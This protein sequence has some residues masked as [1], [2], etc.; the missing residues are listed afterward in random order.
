MNI[1]ISNLM[2]F[3]TYILA[4]IGVLAFVVS[5]IVQAVKEMPGLSKIP[6]AAVALVVSM[7]ICPVAMLAAMQYYKQPVTW[8][9]VFACIIAAFVVYLVS[10]GGWS[11]LKEI[12]DRTKYDKNDK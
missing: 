11:K 3:M 1:D 6:T 2:Q 8:Y 5:V 10:T 4:F 12:W 9:Y 7:I